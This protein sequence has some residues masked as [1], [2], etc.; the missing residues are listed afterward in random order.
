MRFSVGHCRT[1]GLYRQSTTGSGSC[2]CAQG[3]RCILYPMYFI[4]LVFF[5]T[6]CKS[7]CV[8]ARDA[9]MIRYG[10]QSRYK[11]ARYEW[12]GSFSVYR[13]NRRL[14]SWW[15]VPWVTGS[16]NSAIVSVLPYSISFYPVFPRRLECTIISPAFSP[17]PKSQSLT[18]AATRTTSALCMQAT[19]ETDSAAKCEWINTDELAAPRVK[20]MQD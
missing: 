19:R 18:R 10:S 15:I 1:A 3:N 14:K 17:L 16:V 7:T 9:E 11:R 8:H 5:H 12:I 4:S 20:K 13:Y 6:Q 2:G